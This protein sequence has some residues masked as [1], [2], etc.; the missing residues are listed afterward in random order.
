MTQA[1]GDRRLGCAAAHVKPVGHEVINTISWA[2]AG[3]AMY[4]APPSHVKLPMLE[5]Q[6]DNLGE[7]LQCCWCHRLAAPHSVS[8][9]SRAVPGGNPKPSH[10]M[11]AI[12]TCII[13]NDI[14]WRHGVGLDRRALNICN[15]CNVIG[16]YAAL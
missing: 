2:Q 14:G 5:W 11:A 15:V 4:M 10:S 7:I 1:I 6:V 8:Q 3:L 12:H 16:R 9:S 13:I